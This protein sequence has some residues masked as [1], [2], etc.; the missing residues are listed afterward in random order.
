VGTLGQLNAQAISGKIDRSTVAATVKDQDLPKTI[1][2][3]N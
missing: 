1:T 3:E 2:M